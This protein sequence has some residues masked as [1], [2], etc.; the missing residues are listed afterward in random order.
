VFS[1]DNSFVDCKFIWYFSFASNHLV[2]YTYYYLTI[3]RFNYKK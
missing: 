1:S 3:N 2:V